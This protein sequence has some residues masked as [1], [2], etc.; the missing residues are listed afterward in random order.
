[1]CGNE[2]RLT[3]LTELKSYV[4]SRVTYQARRRYNRDQ[5][6]EIHG[7]LD[8]VVSPALA[9]EFSFGDPD[10]SAPIR[11]SRRQAPDKPRPATPRAA[12][13]DKSENTGGFFSNF[14][15]ATSDNES[16]SEAEDEPHQQND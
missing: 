14:F 6:P 9:P 13:S 7:K 8:T 1:M 12:E 4:L 16:A 3:E 5:T 11:E 15:R 2:N 10:A